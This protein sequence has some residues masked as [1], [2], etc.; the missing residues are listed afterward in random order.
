MRIGSQPISEGAL[1]KMSDSKANMFDT[2]SFWRAVSAIALIFCLNNMSIELSMGQ[3][4]SLTVKSPAVGSAP[5]P[6]ARTD[7]QA[8]LNASSDSA[9]DS[10]VPAL[11]EAPPNAPQPAAPS[12]EPTD[13]SEP[14]SDTPVGSDLSEISDDSDINIDDIVDDTLFD[15]SNE[16]V[17]LSVEPGTSPVLPKDRP[18]WIGA[19]PDFTTDVHRLYVASSA[20]SDR[21]EA[22]SALNI[23]LIASMR[24]YL[25]DK[26]FGE[27]GA[28]SDV[29]L[30]A[31]YIR[32]NMVEQDSSV[33][34]ELNTGSDPMYQKWV[35]VEITP[36][37]RQHL[38]M[39]RQQSMQID[40]LAPLGAGLAGLLG[41]VGITHMLFRRK[42][43][44][45][46]AQPL[47]APNLVANESAN[48]ARR[49]SSGGF[50]ALFV[51][52]MLCGGFVFLF[53]SFIFVARSS[54]RQ[55]HLE[56]SARQR[57]YD[58]QEEIQREIKKAQ[59][60]VRQAQATVTRELGQLGSVE[61]LSSSKFSEDEGEFTIEAGG[62]TIRVKKIK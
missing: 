11:A 15:A 12:S 56:T 42:H 55:M 26:V 59:E 7:V 36:E 16:P 1:N 24:E 21:D 57:A 30:T 14:A 61:S 20:V 35:T 5:G 8:N 6:V 46:T 37:Q 2:A 38:S 4:S 48:I 3:D 52:F 25:D 23:P 31:D 39:Q 60:E 28:S 50:G 19:E 47:A 13:A 32:K 49:K 22:D 33:V 58:A 43:G 54:S 10:D 9:V 40:R 17:Q 45:A 29:N 53:F 18:A 34:L 44:L 51:L 41:L 62:Q 27:L